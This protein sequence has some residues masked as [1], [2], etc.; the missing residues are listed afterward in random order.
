[1]DLNALVHAVL[2]ACQLETNNPVPTD[3]ELQKLRPYLGCKP[4]EVVRKALGNT[5]LLAKLE[6]RLPMRHHIKSRIPQ[7][8]ASPV[9]ELYAMDT[10]L[11]K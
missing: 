11:P 7:L 6:N 4:L 5:T 9:R 8:N 2:T 3:E 10:I 1:M